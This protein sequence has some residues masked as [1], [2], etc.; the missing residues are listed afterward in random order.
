[1]SSSLLGP[2]LHNTALFYVP[3][4]KQGKKIQNVNFRY[5]KCV[6]YASKKWQNMVLNLICKERKIVISLSYKLLYP[7]Y[8]R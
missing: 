5:V 2:Q 6:K 3:L 8:T 4:S 7:D 1:M